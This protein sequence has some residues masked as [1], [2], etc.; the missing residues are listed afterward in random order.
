MKL[1]QIR[2]NNNKHLPNAGLHVYFGNITASDRT[3]PR[4]I[5]LCDEETK[6]PESRRF[7]SGFFFF[8]LEPWGLTTSFHLRP[9]TKQGLTIRLLKRPQISTS[10]ATA[11]EGTVISFYFSLILLRATRILMHTWRENAILLFSGQIKRIWC[12]YSEILFPQDNLLDYVEA[13]K[14]PY[15]KARLIPTLD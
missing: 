7:Y 11:T 2:W 3:V 13:S 5:K 6:K 9:R 8:F 14:L 1:G 15:Y 12:S 4:T 10:K